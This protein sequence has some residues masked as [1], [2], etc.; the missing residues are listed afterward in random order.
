MA[1]VKFIST[2]EVAVPPR[3]KGRYVNYHLNDEQLLKDGY[4]P[5]VES[6]EPEESDL[7]IKK[8]AERDGK[9]IMTYQK[10]NIIKK[11]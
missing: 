6:P 8:Y 2:Y 9:I 4:L 3:T 10:K 11:K 1:Y 5:L 7:Y